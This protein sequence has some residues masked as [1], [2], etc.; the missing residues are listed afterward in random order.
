MITGTSSCDYEHNK[1][2]SVDSFLTP[3]NITY[4]P[5]SKIHW[6]SE[7]ANTSYILSVLDSYDTLFI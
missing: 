1:T 3:E 2:L 7:Y 4:K 5:I 6:Y